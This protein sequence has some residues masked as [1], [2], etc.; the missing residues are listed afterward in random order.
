MSSAFKVKLEVVETKVVTRFDW[1]SAG[2]PATSQA[3]EGRS[4]T[5]EAEFTPDEAHE[6]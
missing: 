2:G 1:G 3:E 6:I 5:H 4:D